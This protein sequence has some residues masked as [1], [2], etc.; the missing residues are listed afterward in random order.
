MVTKN[1]LQPKSNIKFKKLNSS[2]NIVFI[3]SRVENINCLLLGIK[4]NFEPILV[5]S[6]E[7]FSAILARYT[8]KIQSYNISLVCHGSPGRLFLGSGIV[9]QEYIKKNKQIFKDIKN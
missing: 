1:S 6:E 9:D 8:H 3:D 5:N 4:E 7:E 2:K